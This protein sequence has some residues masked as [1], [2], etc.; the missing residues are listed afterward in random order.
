MNPVVLAAEYALGA[1]VLATFLAASFAVISRHRVSRV[2]VGVLLGV[3]GGFI[4]G[5]AFLDLIPEAQKGA[6]NNLIV[7]GGIALGLLLMIGLGKLL[8]AFGMGEGEENEEEKKSIEKKRNDSSITENSSPSSDDRVRKASVISLGIAIHNVPEALPIG[9]AIIVSPNLSLLVA[10]LMTGETFAESGA[11]ADELIE[12]KVSA[13][14]IFALTMW[15]SILSMIGAPIGVILAD[16]SP[17]LLG[18]TLSLAAGIMLFITG[19]VW[20]DSRKDAGV[21]WSSIGLLVGVLLAVLSSAI[22][23]GAT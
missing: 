12:T 16:I 4:L 11:I 8:G 3:S 5:V 23:K 21:A 9:A 10:L 18:V 15:P 19:E 2:A 6:Q 20:S 14:R 17:V 1:D 22:V 7:A 13:T